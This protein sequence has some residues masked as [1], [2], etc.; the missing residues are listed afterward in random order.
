MNTTT[1]TQLEL[2][3]SKSTNLPTYFFISPMTASLLINIKPNYNVSFHTNNG[4]IGALDWN[5]GVMKF[6]GD[7]DESAKVFFDN[8]I[9]RYFPNTATIEI[10]NG[11]KITDTIVFLSNH[12]AWRR[13]DESIEMQNPKDIGCAID[14]AIDLLRKYDK[15]QKENEQLKGLLSDISGWML[16]NDYDCGQNGSRLYDHI[17]N[18]LEQNERTKTDE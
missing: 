12:N 17:T 3:F 11:S 1:E 6:E 9:G 10:K 5:D 7:A 13:G 18:V 8:V 4:M 16:D 14:D 2:D 15:M